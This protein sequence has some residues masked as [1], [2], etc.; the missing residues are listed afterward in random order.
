MDIRPTPKQT[1]PNFSSVTNAESSSSSTT[2]YGS[3]MSV[4]PNDRTTMMRELNQIKAEIQQLH[5][6]NGSWEQS[7]KLET[8]MSDIQKRLADMTSPRNTQDLSETQKDSEAMRAEQTDANDFSKKSSEVSETQKKSP[9]YT[10]IGM[11]MDIYA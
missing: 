11:F 5:N 10:F 3:S 8:Q 4:S 2:K 6:E 1:L 9:F 7:Q